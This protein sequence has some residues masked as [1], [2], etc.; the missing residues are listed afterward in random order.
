MNNA[1]FNPTKDV[2]RSGMTRRGLLQ[3]LAGGLGAGLLMTRSKSAAAPLA[4]VADSDSPEVMWSTQLNVQA[5]NGWLPTYYRGIA[6]LV[7]PGSSNGDAGAILTMDIHSGVQ[8]QIDTQVDDATLGQAVGSGPIILAPGSDGAIWGVDSRAFGVA[9]PLQGPERV[10]S[11]LLPWNGLVLYLGTSGDLIAVNISSVNTDMAPVVWQTPTNVQSA[12]GAYLMDGGGGRVYLFTQTQV[13]QMRVSS[14]GASVAWQMSPAAS[15]GAPLGA[16]SSCDGQFVYVTFSKLVVAYNAADGSQGPIAYFR[17]A[18]RVAA[19][20]GYLYYADS[21]GNFTARSITTG[22]IAWETTLSGDLTDGNIYVEDGVAYVCD[23]S[24][25][26]VYAIRLDSQG[27][28]FLKYQTGSPYTQIVGVENGLCIVVYGAAGSGTQTPLFEIAG[29]DLATQINGFA[30]ESVLMADNYVAGPQPDSP[31]YRT[32]LQL[33]DPNKNPRVYKSVKV[34]ASGAVTITSGGVSYNIDNNGNAGWLLTDEAG[35][36]DIVSPADDVS[37]PALYLWGSFMDRQEAIVIYPDHQTSSDLHSAN[38]GAMSSAKTYS[39]QPVLPSG[40]DPAQLQTAINNVIGSGISSSSTAVQAKNAAAMRAHQAAAQIKAGRRGGRRRLLN[41]MDSNTYIAYPATTTNLLYQQA[42]G[43]STR[44][45]AGGTASNFTAT[46]TPG[47]GLNIGPWQQPPLSTGLLGGFFSDLVSDVTYGIDA[48][49]KITVTIADDLQSA[50][51]YI[52]TA[53]GK[54]Y[55]LAVATFED[56]VAV[57]GALF[58]SV[59][60]DIEKAVEWLSYLFDWEAIKAAKGTF[61]GWI[62]AF[63]G[64]NGTAQMD[65]HSSDRSHQRYS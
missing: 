38:A 60:G 32:R 17:P 41:L 37:S 57:L 4:R 19:Y 51:H 9:S 11:N 58:K 16:L 43:S 62:T 48:I 52:E 34:W 2:R 3:T 54:V 56:A 39:G 6:T 36:L 63:L 49:T 23:Q 33:V 30:C 47:A 1:N 26:L 10:I 40:V 12:A 29:V 14:Q 35:E 21:N 24:G 15:F 55:N 53:A 20:G 65:R 61:Q 64:P 5:S 27:V 45:F 42:V 50:A 59:L 7:H 31:V 25:G 28:D 8:N 13:T 44:P 18:S 22:Q 46:I